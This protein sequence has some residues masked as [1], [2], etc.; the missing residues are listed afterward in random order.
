M[1]KLLTIILVALLVACAKDD[2]I[3]GERVQIL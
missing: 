2:N 1:R 3:G